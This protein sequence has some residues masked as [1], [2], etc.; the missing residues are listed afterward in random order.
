MLKQKVR[1]V[2]SIGKPEPVLFAASTEGL[3]MDSAL[4]NNHMGKNYLLKTACQLFNPEIC[5]VLH[6]LGLD[7]LTNFNDGQEDSRAAL[8]MCNNL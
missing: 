7:K 3:L 8:E 2:N 6:M 4:K 1:M 5:S